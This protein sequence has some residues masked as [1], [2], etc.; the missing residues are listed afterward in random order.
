MRNDH[1]IVRPTA[2]VLCT[3]ALI[4]MARGS[5]E[6][7]SSSSVVLEATN[8]RTGFKL[9]EKELLV[10]LT[11]D[12]TV[13]WDES[14]RDSKYA[15]RVGTISSQEVEDIRKSLDA[16]DKR[17][18]R[19][20]MGPYYYVLD[21]RDELRLRVE[22]AKGGLRFSVKNPW[23]GLGAAKPVPTEVRLIICEASELRTKMT[24]EPL[25]LERLCESGQ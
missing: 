3:F 9:R 17:G 25:P 23:S 2:V 20:K 13:E 5:R 6:Q 12:G 11:N 10:R 14:V 22:T 4:A 16:I 7:A 19:P 18:I 1:A 24:A 8:F 21:V 15:R